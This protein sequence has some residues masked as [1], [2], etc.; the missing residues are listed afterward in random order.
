MFVNTVTKYMK[1][2]EYLLYMD[3]VIF[4]PLHIL[5]NPF[6]PSSSFCLSV[7]LEFSFSPAAFL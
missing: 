5:P 6:P 4:S 2:L 3:S 7:C 1:L